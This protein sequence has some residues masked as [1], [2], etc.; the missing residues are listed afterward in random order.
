MA[1]AHVS[2]S[3]V[4]YGTRTNTTITAPVTI[5]N[6]NLLGIIYEIGANVAPPTPTPPTGFNVATG[7]PINRADSNGFRVDTYLWTKLASGEAG[8]YT[9]THSSATSN[10]YMWNVSGQ[11]LITPLDPNPTTNTGLGTTA[12]ALGLTTS[13]DGSMIIYWCSKWNFPGITPPGGTTPTLTTRLDGSASLLFVSDGI[14]SPQGATGDKVATGLPQTGTEP[15]ASGLIAIKAASTPGGT[16]RNS[17][18]MLLHNSDGF[19]L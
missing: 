16:T 18:I 5:S 1:V 15:W 14:L 17:R 6:D 8:D 9:V 3:S 4:L 2:S 13:V 12:T 7:F 11:N 10:A 19:L